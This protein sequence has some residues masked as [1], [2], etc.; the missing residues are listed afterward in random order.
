MSVTEEKCFQ[1]F[2]NTMGTNGYKWGV[3]NHVRDRSRE[4]TNQEFGVSNVKVTIECTT[5]KS[6]PMTNYY[7]N[8]TQTITGTKYKFEEYVEKHTWAPMFK[9][10][11]PPG[12]YK[13]SCEKTDWYRHNYLIP[14]TPQKRF[15]CSSLG[16]KYSKVEF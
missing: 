13:I 1:A 9:Y 2:G 15:E 14:S 5:C 8:R 3:C 12:K 11:V 16:T 6:N 7:W 4:S 10:A